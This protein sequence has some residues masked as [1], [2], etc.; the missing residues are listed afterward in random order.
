MKEKYPWWLWAGGA[1]SLWPVILSPLFLFGNPFG[2][3]TKAGVA[4]RLFHVIL[5][6]IPWILPMITVIAGF[7]LYR[8]GWYLR[9]ALLVGTTF[10]LETALAAYLY[11][12]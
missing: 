4:E 12:Y 6:N 3:D 9:A 5:T 11:F 7:D 10:L 2:F 8:R 1:L